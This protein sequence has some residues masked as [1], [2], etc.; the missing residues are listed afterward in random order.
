MWGEFF[1]FPVPGQSSNGPAFSILFKQQETSRIRLFLYQK[2]HG[3][4]R[5][6]ESSSLGMVQFGHAF[7]DRNH[8]KCTIVGI[9][10]NGSVIH[11]RLS[12][13]LAHHRV[14][15]SPSFKSW[16]SIKSPWYGNKSCDSLSSKLLSTRK[17]R[18]GERDRKRERERDLYLSLEISPPSSLAATAWRQNRS[19]FRDDK[20]GFKRENRCLIWKLLIV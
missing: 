14:I 18:E 20:T 17:E 15:I 1:L 19:Q 10:V 9:R 6:K 11:R 8:V 3:L 16:A 7:F 5:F 13:G 4:L 12:G 2:W